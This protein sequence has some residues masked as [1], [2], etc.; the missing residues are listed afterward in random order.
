[1]TAVIDGSA[2][3]TREALHDELHRQLALPDYYGRT[4]DALYDCLTDLHEETE[5]RVLHAAALEEHLGL[6]AGVMRRMLSDAC[7]ENPR[8]RFIWEE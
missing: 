1:M 8:L 2:I 4:L 3:E 5:L 6:Y 7:E